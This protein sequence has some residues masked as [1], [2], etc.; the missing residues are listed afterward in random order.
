MTQKQRFQV[1]VQPTAPAGAPLAALSHDVIASL[2]GAGRIAWANLAWRR[3]LG[4]APE[5]LTGTSFVELLHPDDVAA[6]RALAGAGEDGFETAVRVRTRSGGSRRMAFAAG[7][8]P[9]EGVTYVCGRDATQTEELEHE[10]RAAEDRFR[11]VTEATSTEAILTADARGRIT[12]AN[13]A[14]RSMFG[15][16]A[17]ELLGQPFTMLV[18]KRH[19]EPHRSRM[20]RAVRTGEQGVFG[21][22]VEVKGVRRDG[23][24]FPIEVSLGSWERGGR[25][26][27]T[28]ILRDVTERREMLRDLERSNAEL[29][30][31]AYVASHD[32][33]EP[34][35]MISSYLQLLRRRH[36]DELHGEAGEFVGHAIEGATRMRSLIE[37]LL[38]Y[39]RS[40]RSERP[41][42]P[43]DLDALVAS[44]AATI[45]SGHTDPRPVIEWSE[46]PTVPGDPAQLAQL[47]QN[48]ISNGVKFV[49]PGAVPY[50]CV[51]AEREPPAWR[52]VVDDNGIG[53]EPRHA[54]RIFGMFQRLHTREAFPGTGI[55]L[56]IARKVVES[57]GG[58]IWVE[59]RPEGGTRFAFTLPA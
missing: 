34:L 1:A 18:P 13:A 53:I 23:T 25:R 9:A 21:E 15:W 38:A 56:A 32:L 33:S 3:A 58:R 29:A 22:S 17:H 4:W 28:A 2:D 8:A 55:G 11:A 26:A 6:G 5:E 14:A 20:R 16:D 27:F 35:R 49:A 51:T 40:G 31:F 24:E 43:V 39:S 7:A 59:P 47:L 30:Q 36:G 52:L 12:F 37:D 42:E 44:I 57:H 46:L 45:V 48:L 19:R 10:L 41:L 54:E 50:V